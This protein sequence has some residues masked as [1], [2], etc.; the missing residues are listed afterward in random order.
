M[1]HPIAKLTQGPLWASAKASR[2]RKSWIVLGE[3]IECA[4]GDSEEPSGFP[5][6]DESTWVGRN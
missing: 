5:T 2:A 6:S 1:L 4:L 3:T